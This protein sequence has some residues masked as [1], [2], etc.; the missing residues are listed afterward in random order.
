MFNDFYRG[1]RVL[2]TGH[3]GFKGS[4]LSLWLQAL[5]AEVAGVSAYLP[6]EPCNFQVLGLGRLMRD[7]TGDIQDFPGMQRLFADFNPEV[8]FHL[9]AQPLVRLSYDSPKLTFDANIGGTVN[10]LECIRQTPGVTAAIIITSDKCYDNVGWPWGYRE[11]DRLGGDDPYSASKAAAEIV[12]QSY[13]QSFFAKATQPR[14]VAVRAGNVVGGGDW[15]ADR[16]IPDCVRAWGAGDK[17][18]IRHPEAVRAWNHVLETLSG[19]LWLGAQMSHNPELGGEAFNFGPQAELTCSV[20]TLV[21]G[22]RRH[23]DQAQWTQGG[24]DP[25]KR[26]QPTLR[27]CVDKAMALL[28][29]RPVL[30]FEQTVELTATWYKLYYAGHLDMLDLSRRQI[31]QYHALVQA[32]G[33][34]WAAD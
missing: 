9:A 1:K 2:L 15:A 30:T 19:Y 23:W 12:V 32:A 33:L 34:A 31:A 16:L 22:F 5:G 26:E 8:V 7:E 18:H 4:W 29:W 27:L 28:A 14:V 20:Q 17:V 25:A 24:I 3:T 21:E 11:N 10:V 6:S 13:Y